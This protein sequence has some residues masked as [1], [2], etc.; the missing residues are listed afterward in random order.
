M[1]TP[2]EILLD[3]ISLSII[4]MFAALMIWEALF[5]ARNLAVV[6][7]LKLR[8]LV[9]FIIFFFLSSYLP[10]FWDSYLVEYQLINMSH[11]N[12]IPAT[13]I[14]L[15]VYEFG[16]YIWHRLIHKSDFLWKTFH[17]MHHSAEN[18]DTYGA[19]YFSPLDMIGWTFLG[20]LSLTL[21]VGLDPQAVTNIV[22][23]TTFFAI[24]Q[25]ANIRTPVW[26]GYFVQRPESHNIHHAKN[27][28]AFNYS[29]LPLFDVLFGT[30]NN[31]RIFQGEN[32]FYNGASAKV[33]D[34][35]LCKNISHD[36]NK[37][38]KTSN[39]ILSP[40]LGKNS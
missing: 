22:L 14:G 31:P 6:K 37:Y 40:N 28:H 26:L 18:V 9:A 10:L 32:G 11:I 39:D 15:L 34:M 27:I 24:F 21:I 17:Q 16:V 8:G 5:L 1:P 35:L 7:G 13:L 38:H 3:P 23:L 19:F 36:S 25:H 30:F 12:V 4:F 29:D 33:G 20:S 2:I